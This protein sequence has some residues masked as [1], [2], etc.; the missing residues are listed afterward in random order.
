MEIQNTSLSA[1][2]EPVTV[3]T[4]ERSPSN[5]AEVYLAS[6]GS[7]VSRRTM[8]SPLNNA[9]R[10]LDPTQAGKYAWKHIPWQRITAPDVRRFMAGLT[11]SPATRNKALAALKGVARS[12]WELR[13]LDGEELARI[14]NIKGDAGSR[15][16][17]GRYVPADEIA[18]L[19]RTCAHDRTAAGVRDAALIAVA[20]VTGMR[21]AEI[22]SLQLESLKELEDSGYSIRLIGKR[23]KERT[24]YI[25]GNA[26][27]FLRDW[28]TL[29]KLQPGYKIGKLFC[30]IRKSGAIVEGSALSTTALDRILRKRSAL[31]K[32]DDL[33]WHDLRR[34][35]TSNLLDSGADIA[36]VAKILGHS[37][38]QTT[39]RYDLRG[40]RA[41]IA[42]SQLV[43]VPYFMPSGQ[44]SM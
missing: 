19:L 13:L 21:R 28:L 41:K 39:A 15:E 23:N 35:V 30:A 25:W 5:P 32:I 11:G 33:D 1:W 26:A 2:L 27:Q 9:A 16:I 24:A 43:S 31:A 20:V 17:T 12:A 18:S 14:Q 3:L 22:A 8:I 42:A 44:K 7:E 37:N 38:I 6:L 10:V 40:E 34:T 36:T 29:A 4:A